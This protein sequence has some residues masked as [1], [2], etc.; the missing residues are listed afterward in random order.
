MSSTPP[1]AWLRL[2]CCAAP[3]LRV[4]ATSR[5]A[6]GLAGEAA[7]RVPSLE[8]RGAVELF[9]DRAGQ[10]RPG[11][12]ADADETE[13]IAR[14]CQRLD[15]LPL[16]IELAAAR[17]RMM[18]PA[19]IAAGLDD[20]FRL[21]TGGS[22]TAVPRQQTL[23]ASV[24]WSYALLAEEERALLRRLSVFAGGFSLE[25]AEAVCADGEL[26]EEYA[27]L[28]LVSRLVDKSLIVFDDNVG[29][30]RLLETILQF[31][32]ERLVEAE[33]MAATREAH[34]CLLPGLRRAG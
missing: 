26:V 11:W 34:L 29:R 8:E 4:V 2:C 33:E 6:L 16:A 22:R 20:R 13:A 10:A 17:T 31:A 27:V 18:N 9:M 19:R 30:Y 1:E 7:W 14:I 12:Q 25:G 5:E 32:R 15:G 21:L 24:S 23:E 3:R 28:D